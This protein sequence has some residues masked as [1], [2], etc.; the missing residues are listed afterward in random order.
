MPGQKCSVC[1]HPQSFE[2]NEALIIQKA[3]NRGI[4]RQYGVGDDSVQRHRKHIPQL[5]LQASR[6]QEIADADLLLDD[7]ATIRDKT[8]KVLD[9]AEVS[10]D[11]ATMLKAIREARENVRI[12]GELHGR[13]GAR[14]ETRPLISPVA[15]NV[16]VQ[17]L[18]PHPELAVAVADA[19]EPL[20]ELE[21]AG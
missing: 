19:L 15:M 16:I 21:A 12:L 11:W 10:E 14:V 6:S 2:I 18:A 7:I 17:I 20:E 13:L 5:L 1:T 3:S 4:A 9:N 8:F